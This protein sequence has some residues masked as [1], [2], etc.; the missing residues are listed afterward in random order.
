VR[1]YRSAVTLTTCFEC[2]NSPYAGLALEL[3]GNYD[4]SI[5]LFIIYP[6]VK[7]NLRTKDYTFYSNYSFCHCRSK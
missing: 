2:E 5:R 1:I 3:E 6:P 4:D 7:G